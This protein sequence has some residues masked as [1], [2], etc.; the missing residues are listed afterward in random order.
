M[1]TLSS[2]VTTHNDR[3]QPSSANS[4]ANRQR[5]SRFFPYN[6]PSRPHSALKRERRSI[7]ITDYNAHATKVD[8]Q[9]LMAK[10]QAPGWREVKNRLL[11]T[12]GDAAVE[13]LDSLQS[14]HICLHFF[15][16]VID[17]YLVARHELT[18]R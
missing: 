17:E 4:R 16:F 5:S 3:A 6:T 14:V 13:L 10:I 8:I 11:C 18:T 15:A 1:D 7:E 12:R 9:V 2:L